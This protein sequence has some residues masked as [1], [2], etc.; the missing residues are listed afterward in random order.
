MSVLTNTNS[1]IGIIASILRYL[2]HNDLDSLSL[3]CSTG[4]VVV[5][6]FR[7]SAMK[8]EKVLLRF[9][10]NKDEIGTFQD[11]Q[12]KTG[13]IISG[14]VALQ[15]FTRIDYDGSDLDT[16]SLLQHC[17]EIGKWLLTIGYNY[18][19]VKN[20][21]HV[22]E[23]DYDRIL[24]S[25]GPSRVNNVVN[26]GDDI[27]G[28]TRYRSVNIHE[29]WNFQR[30][31]G[32]RVQLVATRIIPEAIVLGFHSTCVMN[33]ITHKAAY[34]LFPFTT[35][36]KTATVLV[37]ARGRLLRQYNQ[38]VQKYRHRGFM[39]NTTVPLKYAIAGE[40]GFTVPRWIGDRRTWVYPVE[41]Y[42]KGKIPNDRAERV[43]WDIVYQGRQTF[44]EYEGLYTG[45][46]EREA[47]EEDKQFILA[48]IEVDMFREFVG[49]DSRMLTM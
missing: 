19:P 47:Y 26:E 17:I 9:F 27:R 35:F 37:N 25:E 14:S 12:A 18:K 2:D 45:D 15:F 13:A 32:V 23:E 41:Y 44:M 29:V 10:K 43:S 40:Y 46:E 42:G 38:A 21:R 4:N 34:S 48:R 3:T 39:V 5:G 36:K 49:D 31:D 20:Q 8:I 1:D 7:T 33:I 22:F 24:Q 30:S 16:Y 6:I 11:I 28:G